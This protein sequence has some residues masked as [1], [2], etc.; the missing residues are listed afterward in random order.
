MLLLTALLGDSAVSSSCFS[1]FLE[2]FGC[3]PCKYV[4]I[5]SRLRCKTDRGHEVLA[6]T[7][8]GGVTTGVRV[9][10]DWPIVTYVFDLAVCS[11]LEYLR[12]NPPFSTKPAS[13]TIASVNRLLGECD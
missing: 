2:S 8:L 11:R 4:L 10:R 9:R 3:L 12:V 13:E 5:F 1:E 6:N 7:I